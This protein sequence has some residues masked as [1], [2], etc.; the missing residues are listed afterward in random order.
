MDLLLLLVGAVGHTVLWIALTNRTHALGIPRRWVNILTLGCIAMFGIMPLVV[1]AAFISMLRPEPSLVATLFFAAAKTYVIACVAVGLIAAIKWLYWRFHTERRGV[2]LSNHSATI[3]VA[4]RV[5]EPLCG[6]GWAGKLAAMP[7]NQATRIS[8]HKKEILL[9]RLPSRFAGI[10]IV[11][12]ADLHMSGRLTKAYFEFIVDEVNRCEADLIAVTG[13]IVEFEPCL[14]WV[15]DTVGRLRAAGGVYYVLG[16]HDR[17]AGPP[18]V[19]AALDSSGLINVGSTLREVTI[20]DTRLIVGGNELP[21]FSPPTDFG[22]CPEHDD[23]GQPLRLLLAHTPDQFDWAYD[24][25]IDLMLAGHV[26]GGQVCLP[27]VGPL[28]APSMHGVR[29]ASG[30]F[31]RGDTVMHVTR[32][33][34]SLTPLRWNCPPEIS[35]LTIRGSEHD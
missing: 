11:H 19:R 7:G 17:R 23:D 5:A 25:D 6:P 3:K 26:H 4:D 24:H 13:D 1:A 34:S 2:L 35:V 31:R 18:Q 29:Y 14:E 32:G 28:T 27:I 16:N 22:H 8:I 15:P 30:I 9:P 10:K 21:W 20:R 12:L 33:A